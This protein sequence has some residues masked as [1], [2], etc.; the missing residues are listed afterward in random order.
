[1]KLLL[2]LLVLG[3]E[4]TLVCVHAE[5]KTSLTGKNFNPEKIVG[6]CHSILLASDKREMIEEHGSMRVF[7]KSIHLFKNSSLAF[8]FHTIVNGECTE[9][10]VVCDKTEEDGVY[11][12]IYDGYNR[13]TVLGTNYDEY[14]IFK[15][16]NNKTGEISHVME[17]FGRKPE[18]SSNIK[19]MFGVLCK[20][21]GIVKE[22][23]LDLTEANRCL[24]ARDG[25]NA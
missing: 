7:V 9:L 1:M 23:I 21:N 17:L 11:E 25:R 15:L 20:E 18:L 14:I 2:L 6:E 4:L 5:E 22:N 3:L 8:K 13:F 16:R 19:E 24:Q 10:Y 12:V